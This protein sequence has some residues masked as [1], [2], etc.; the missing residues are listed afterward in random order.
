MFWMSLPPTWAQ[1]LGLPGD[2]HSPPPGIT[3]GPIQEQV[4][5]PRAVFCLSISAGKG[6]GDHQILPVPGEARRLGVGA[7]L[8]DHR[9]QQS[10]VQAALH[11]QRQLRPHVSARLG[12]RGPLQATLVSSGEAGVHWVGSVLTP[13]ADCAGRWQL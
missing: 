1:L 6:A 2:L 4:C 10:L 7:E 3:F 9:A 8:C 13:S 5:S 11:R 12:L